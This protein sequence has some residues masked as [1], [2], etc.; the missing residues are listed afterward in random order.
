MLDAGLFCVLVLFGFSVW[1]MVLFVQGNV[2]G[3]FLLWWV[4]IFRE[5]FMYKGGR[6]V[7]YGS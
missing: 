3:V 6:G 7:K 4:M 1:G 5:W 2:D